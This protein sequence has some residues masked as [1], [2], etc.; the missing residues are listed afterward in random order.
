MSGKQRRALGQ[1][2]GTAAVLAMEYEKVWRNKKKPGIRCRYLKMWKA[3]VAQHFGQ[4]GLARN[5]GTPNNSTSRHS[6]MVG[7]CWHQTSCLHI[8][9]SNSQNTAKNWFDRRPL[10][11][12]CLNLTSLAYLA[13]RHVALAPC[14][15][16]A[17]WSSPRGAIGTAWLRGRASLAKCGGSVTCRETVW[18]VMCMIIMM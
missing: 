11:F 4:L 5:D 17:S 13:S 16:A 2:P 8:F 15:V 9:A 7:T 10:Y 1:I 3:S 14:F 18:S 12:A 6:Q